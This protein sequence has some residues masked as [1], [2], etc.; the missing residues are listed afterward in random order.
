MRAPTDLRLPVV[1]G[2]GLT[3]DYPEANLRH[4]AFMLEGLREVEL[5]SAERGIAFVMRRGRAG[6]RRPRSSRSVPR[7]SSAIAATC[8]TRGRGARAWRSPPVGGWCRSKATWSCRS[9]SRRTSARP[10]RARCGRRSRA[11][12]R[13]TSSR[14]GLHASRCATVVWPMIAPVPMQSRHR[15]SPRCS[16]AS[17]STG[18]SRRSRA[19]AAGARRPDGAA[20]VPGRRARPATPRSADEPALGQ[21]SFLAAY[22][23]FGQIS[24]VE[25]ALRVREP[26]PLSED[27]AAFL[28]E[29]IV[30]RELA[31]NFVHYEP[32][33]DRYDCAARAGRATRSIGIADDPRAAPLRRRGARG[34]GTHDPLLERR[35]ARDARHRLHAQPHAD[36]LGQEDPRMVGEPR[37]RRSRPRWRSTTA[38]S[39]MAAIPIPTPTSPGVSACTTGPGPSARSSARCAP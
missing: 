19:F 11:C 17:I 21:V 4:Y 31:I 6:R 33:Y 38:T 12:A 36:V 2:F 9:R 5:G 1:V 26:T 16:A 39:S 29:L 8:A 37:G 14:C 28:E 22:L 34:G 30:R 27:R 35:D 32:D 18:R 13:V 15:T 25:I 10:R 20:R 24:P 3:D 7:W 23:H